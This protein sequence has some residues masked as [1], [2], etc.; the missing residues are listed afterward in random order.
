MAAS[1][2]LRHEQVESVFRAH[3]GFPVEDVQEE[4]IGGAS[5]YTGRVAETE[6]PV[7]GF[8]GIGDIYELNRWRGMSGWKSEGGRTVKSLEGDT[9]MFGRDPEELADPVHNYKKLL[10]VDL[11]G[12]PFQT[13]KKPERGI[14]AADIGRGLGVFGNARL[15][16]G[17]GPRFSGSRSD[18]GEH[19]ISWDR[20]R[21]MRDLTSSLGDLSPEQVRRM[22]LRRPYP[23]GDP[24]TD[25]F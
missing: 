11:R 21:G 7:L 5:V 10:A 3:S 1:D 25:K 23:Q 12:M 24:R 8:R 15:N 13:L 20:I 17:F 22:Q 4:I 6:H 9:T 19:L 14:V 16:R 18:G 2:H